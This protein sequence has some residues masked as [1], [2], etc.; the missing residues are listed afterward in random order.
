MASV[1]VDR[2]RT[3]TA[4]DGGRL[5]VVLVD[6]E[7]DVH[8]LVRRRLERSGGFEVVGVARDGTS[9]LGAVD[10]L[11]PDVVLL[12]LDLGGE[13]GTDLIG[14]CMCR[15]PYA[16]V[17]ALTALPAAEHEGTTRRLGAFSFY[18]KGQLARLP[19]HIR[20]DHALFARALAGRH[21]VAPAAQHA[22][23]SPV[24]D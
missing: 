11:Q 13:D 23:S 8:L 20:R 10:R 3:A 16:M 18:E 12:D 2:P 22:G 24:I 7:P 17:A 6:D 15:C 5:R 14:P 21:V 4:T 19:D 1:L 9:A